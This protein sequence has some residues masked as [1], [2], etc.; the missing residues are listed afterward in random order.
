[1][2]TYIAFYNGKKI[3]FQAES[4]YAAKIKGA[5]LLGAKGRKALQ[6]AVVLADVPVDPAGL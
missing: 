6:V 3:E 5:A 2:R 4:L 1:M